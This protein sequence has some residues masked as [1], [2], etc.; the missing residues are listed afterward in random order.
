MAKIKKIIINLLVSII[1]LTIL[2]QIYWGIQYTINQN[3]Y[4]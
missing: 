2:T 1:M 4:L 3:K